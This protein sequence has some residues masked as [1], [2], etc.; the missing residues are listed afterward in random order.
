MPNTVRPSSIQTRW[1]KPASVCS[2][3]IGSAPKSLRYPGPVISRPRPVTATWLSAGKAMTPTLAL[4]DAPAPP[5]PK[6]HVP[7][8]QLI[9]EEPRP[10]RYQPIGQ[11]QGGQQPLEPALLATRPVQP[12]QCAELRGQEPRRREQ[13]ER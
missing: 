8:V 7:Q 3:S 10:M 1:R 12:H 4:D 9:A 2:S 11:P 6:A 13:V 5:R